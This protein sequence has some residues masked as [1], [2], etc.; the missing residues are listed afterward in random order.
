[1]ASTLV[2][3][4]CNLLARG[5]RQNSQN[6]VSTSF[7][8][9]VVRPLFLVAMPG[10]PSSVLLLPIASFR[11]LESLAL[12]QVRAGL[13]KGILRGGQSGSRRS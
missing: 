11:V 5:R 6:I 1:M 8:L 3:M 4:A 13:R 2:A 10:A 12:G 9:L 7:L